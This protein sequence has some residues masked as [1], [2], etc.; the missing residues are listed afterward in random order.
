MVR[1]LAVIEP[2]LQLALPEPASD[3]LIIEAIVPD[4][5]GVASFHQVLLD[6]IGSIWPP[7]WDQVVDQFCTTEALEQYQKIIL[8]LTVTKKTDARILALVIEAFGSVADYHGQG[9]V[10]IV[11]HGHY[12]ALED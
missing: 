11:L 7:G 1:H 6:A 3:T 8:V 5:N 9:K 4:E 10:E 2:K 12:E